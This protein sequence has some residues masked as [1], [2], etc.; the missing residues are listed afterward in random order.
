MRYLLIAILILFVS[1]TEQQDPQVD[2]TGISS[3]RIDGL[4]HHNLDQ[5]LIDYSRSIELNSHGGYTRTAI[6]IADKIHLNETETIKGDYC[7]S[8]CVLIFVSGS[9]RTMCK[10][11]AL[12]LH[13]GSDEQTTWEYLNYLKLDKRLNYKEIENIVLETPNESQTLVFGERAYELGM[14]DQVID[15]D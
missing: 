12:Y 11:E 5:C 15:C 4:I 3:G 9:H 2:C 14:V 10:E 6:R 13:S 1:C 7:G 8:A